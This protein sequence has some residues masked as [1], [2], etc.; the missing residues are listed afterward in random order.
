MFSGRR[1]QGKRT[2]TFNDQTI[3][4]GHKTTKGANHYD[5]GRKSAPAHR[6]NLA[7]WVVSQAL[8]VTECSDI[9]ADAF[10]NSFLIRLGDRFDVKTQELEEELDLAMMI[11]GHRFLLG[12]EFTTG[13]LM[14]TSAAS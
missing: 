12:A 13:M 11:T 14:K 8:G 7:K 2:I 9:F 6:R 3:L 5:W 10:A 1:L 4:D